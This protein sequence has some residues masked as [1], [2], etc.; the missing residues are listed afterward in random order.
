MADVIG[1]EEELGRLE[2]FLAEADGR[3]LL[4][5]GEPGIGKTTLWQAGLE[6]ARRR[7]LLCLTASPARAEAGLSYAALGDLFAPV[8]DEVLEALPAPQARALAVALLLEGAGARPPDRR[9]VAL[10]TLAALRALAERSSIL[11]AVDDVQWLDAPTAFALGFAARRLE[12]E[13][14][15]FLLARRTPPAEPSPLEEALGDVLARVQVGPLG[16]DALHR[17]LVARLGTAVPRPALRRMHAHSGGNPF[18]ALELA[19][20][21]EWSSAGLAPAEALPVTLEALVGDRVAALPER[22]QAALAAAAALSQPTLRTLAAA[23]DGDAEEALSPALAGSVVH[24]RGERVE[25]VHP[26]L[27]SASY[28][29][30]D[31]AAR[32]ALHRRLALVVDD[33]EERARHL[34]LAADGPDEEVAAALAAAAA[35]ARSRGAPET[36]AILAE[37]AADLTPSALAPARRERRAVAAVHHFESGDAPRA[38]EILEGLAAGLDAGP[39]RAG[40]LVRLA[41]VRSYGDDLRGAA[42]LFSRA[43]REAGEDAAVRAAASEGVAACLFRLRERFQEA[44]EHARAAAELA[45]ERG[46]GL[47][48]AEALGTQLAAE[49]LAA[50]PEAAATLEEALAARTEEAAERVL[51]DPEL[52]AAFAWMWWDDL[53]R[54]REAAERLLART[55]EAGD[56]SSRP[57]VLFLLAQLECREGAFAAARAHA[58]QARELSVQAG[59]RWLEAYALALVALAAAYLGDADGCRAAAAEALAL[60][61]RTSG[62]PAEYF[63]ATAL[64]H[65]ELSL[66]ARPPRSAPSSRSSS[67]PP[68]RGSV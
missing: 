16:L 18:F 33:V 54:A 13:P 26:L 45:R 46:D 62:V 25:F 51:A 4:L 23:L 24:L 17:L 5:A 9:A 41:R 20:T 11:V 42:E 64:G 37:R 30:L 47:L 58:E 67:G 65:L 59:Q 31:A 6:A 40:V 15:A 39:E 2:S 43:L 50:L 61:A 68:A 8:R 29:A 53:G 14:I 57:Y 48:A 21:A 56:E 7:G 22:T 10:A 3:A 55:H 36:A 35:R 60:A 1:R 38:R 34:A 12:G 63:A 52:I 27:E 32:R 44:R 49:A 66:G 19:R 28:L